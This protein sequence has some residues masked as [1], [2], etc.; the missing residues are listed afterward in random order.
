MKRIVFLIVAMLII[1]LT[2]CSVLVKKPKIEKLNKVEILKLTPD[3]LW[4]KLGLEV[5]NPNFYALNI[6][7]LEFEVLDLK[8]V[9]VGTGEL[10][11]SIRIGA[12]SSENVSIILH[13]DT[14]R[15]VKTIHTEKRMLGIIIHGYAK[16]KA[17]IF[18]KTQIINQR[19]E[20]SIENYL[21]KWIPDLTMGNKEFFRIKDTDFETGL[22]ESK[23][24][25]YFE[26][27]NP[28]G[29]DYE[30]REFP[31]QL[32]LNGVLAGE[33]KLEQ[34]VV[35]TTETASQSG[36]ITFTL[37]S[38]P[39]MASLGSSLLTGEL[40]YEVRGEIRYRVF[41]V[42]L[43]ND[44]QFGNKLKIDLGALLKGLFKT[45]R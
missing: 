32:Y 36:C 41:G 23:L 6:K 33:G 2:A 16:V 25:V 3:S 8:A 45:H 20:V 29:L 4:V 26:M 30:L 5:N 27:F 15:A 40:S 14:R 31:A 18:S 44:Y 11:E 34:P 21:Q 12:H 10:E 19:Y 42:D 9:Q 13:L 7:E 22:S 39:S 37:Q 1:S 17:L 38:S 24:K 43:K 35:M 28:Y